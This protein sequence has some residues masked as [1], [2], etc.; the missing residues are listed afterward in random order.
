MPEAYVE[1]KTPEVKK[2]GAE[3][4]KEKEPMAKMKKEHKYMAFSK[5]LSP[6]QVF[7]MLSKFKTNIGKGLKSLL[8]KILG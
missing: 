6:Q 3:E 1:K 7:N 2:K 5:K 8:K 4:F